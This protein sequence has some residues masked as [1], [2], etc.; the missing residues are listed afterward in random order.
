MTEPASDLPIVRCDICGHESRVAKAGDPC[1]SNEG[2]GAGVYRDLPKTFEQ[3][4]EIEA[5]TPITAGATPA[6]LPTQMSGEDAVSLLRNF[7]LVSLSN[8]KPLERFIINTETLEYTPQ[9]NPGSDREALEV[10]LGKLD[11]LT[12]ENAELRDTIENMA[13]PSSVGNP[14]WLAARMEDRARRAEAERDTARAECERLRAELEP[15]VSE[16]DYHGLPTNKSEAAMERGMREVRRELEHEN[17]VAECER[18]TH[19]V[20]TLANLGKCYEKQLNEQAATI[21]GLRACLLEMLTEA[22]ES[23]V[24]RP[25]NGDGTYYVKCLWECVDNVNREKRFS[26][27]EAAIAAAL[28]DDERSKLLND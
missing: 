15:V 12:A 2:Y 9:P 7:V 23:R 22:A 26:T 19:T 10:V 28:A 6:E 14:A 25:V 4:A 13:D 27:R 1:C 20:N 5:S 21:A 8:K 18:L 11:A 17:L 16:D 3:A 24:K